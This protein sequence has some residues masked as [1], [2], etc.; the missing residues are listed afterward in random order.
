[1]LKISDRVDGAIV[2]P[3]MPSRARLTMSMPVVVENAASSD[4]APKAAAP[5]SSSR[6]RPMRSPSVPMVMR[7]PATM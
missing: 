5:V 6:R 1:M 2:A 4:T 3:A 7:N